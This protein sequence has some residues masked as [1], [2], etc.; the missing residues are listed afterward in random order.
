LIHFAVVV[1]H[2]AAID[3]M[4][5]Q[6]GSILDRTAVVEGERVEFVGASR[7]WAVAALDFDDHLC[8]ARV[9]ADGDALAVVNGPALAN[10]GD[11][12]RLVHEAL[13]SFRSGGVGAVAQSLGGAY[14]FVGIDPARGTRAFADFS[15]LCPLY[16]AQGADLAV[17]SNRSTTALE[18]VGGK[19]WDSRSL[20]WMIGH[21]NL[22]GDDVPAQSVHYLP[23]GT[24]ARIDRAGSSISV[25]R[26][27]TWVWPEAND[28]CG[29]DD[30]TSE[31]WDAITDDLIA[32]CRAVGRF[33]EG[34]ILNLSGGKDSRLCLALAKAA[35]MGD[36]VVAFTSGSPVSAEAACAREVAR[37]AGVAHRVGGE[38]I[39][40]PPAPDSEVP[41]NARMERDP[42]PGPA[43]TD[44]A[45]W[46]AR[47]APSGDTSWVDDP[48]AV[49]RSLRQATYRYEAIVCPWDGLTP[50]LTGRFLSI[51]GF[52][53][54]LYRGPGGH[55]KRF[56]KTLP[57][58]IDD[59]AAMFVDYHQRIDPLGVL[60]PDVR[61]S[62]AIWLDNWVRESAEHV[63]LDMLPEKFFVDYRLGHWNGPLL[64]AKPTHVI[65]NPLLSQRAALKFF[66]LV[67]DVRSSERLHYEVMRRAAPELTVV[68]FAS[69]RWSEAVL[70]SGPP[71]L[72]REP[73]ASPRGAGAAPVASTRPGPRPTAQTSGPSSPQRPKGNRIAKT[74]QWPFLEGQTKEIAQLFERA[75]RE[76]DMPEICDM[77]ALR[78]AARSA[79][80]ITVNVQGKAL[81]ASICVALALLGEAEPFRDR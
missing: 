64:Q 14:N 11:Q 52:G 27:E 40:V 4:A 39:A 45:G 17:V 58:T 47:S 62:Q 8:D 19:G 59:M 28:G 18:V 71:D 51:K 69:D 49:W 63:R 33:Y 57:S 68:P 75:E 38:P 74:W 31:E 37:V 29:R 25:A 81:V 32:N 5:P 72:P 36:R 76:S 65:V 26:S 20:A 34:A 60:R 42:S 79:A 44:L 77:A 80:D 56:R 53:G 30:L 10:R 16:W 13:A 54:E 50:P 6:L 7:S 12:R 67:P 70:A 61:A 3:R 15:G 24:E 41:R 2:P 66:E 21:S 78:S 43:V 46:R 9:V 23:P 22:F 55:A 1:G 35:G 48:E 73:F